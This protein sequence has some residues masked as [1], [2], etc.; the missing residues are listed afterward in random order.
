MGGGATGLEPAAS[1]VT[2][3]CGLGCGLRMLQLAIDGRAEP[4][5]RARRKAEDILKRIK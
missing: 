2:E 4:L 5:Q 1:A 3:F